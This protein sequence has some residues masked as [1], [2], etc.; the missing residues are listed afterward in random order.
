[1]LCPEAADELY[2]GQVVFPAAPVA[3]L[4]QLCPFCIQAKTH[5]AKSYPSVNTQAR[6]MQLIRHRQV[7]IT[8]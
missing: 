1:M 3:P 2:N 7:T 4:F 8:I 5:S 6:K